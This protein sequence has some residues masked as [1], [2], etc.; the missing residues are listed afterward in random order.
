MS[1]RPC[2][3]CRRPLQPSRCRRRRHDRS[4]RQPPPETARAGRRCRIPPPLPELAAAKAVPPPL[5][6]S[7][8]TPWNCCRCSPKRTWCSCR[9]RPR[10]RWPLPLP[11]RRLLVASEELGTESNLSE[12]AKSLPAV[13]RKWPNLA[14]PCRTIATL[15]SNIFRDRRAVCCG[16]ACR[17]R[18]R[19]CC[20]GCSSGGSGR[21]R[22]RRSWP[23]L[24]C[25][26]SRFCPSTRLPCAAARRSM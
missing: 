18:Q 7:V 14:L 2:R 17:S 15:D 20:S 6:M 11:P 12:A 21:R 8:T 16:P 4:R 5:P 9:F 22:N 25:P 24:R 1:S 26:S 13:A 3:R 10:S 19:F 23:A